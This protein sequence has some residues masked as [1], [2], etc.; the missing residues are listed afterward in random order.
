MQKNNRVLVVFPGKQAS[1]TGWGGVFN[2]TI[3]HIK[4]LIAAE[5]EVIVWTASMPIAEAAEK[6]GAQVDYDPIWHRGLDPL[7]AF[8]CWRKARALKRKGLLGAIHEGGRTGLWGRLLFSGIPQ[9][10]VMHRERIASYRTFKD[11]L[12]LSEGYKKELQ[13]SKSGRRKRIAVAPNA[14]KFDPVDMENPAASIKKNPAPKIG[15][16]GRMEPVKGIDLLIEAAD[17]LKQSGLSFSMELAGGDGGAYRETVH[18][19]GLSEIISFPGWHDRPEE[20]Y[21]HWDIFCLPSRNEPFGLSLIEAMAT[22]IPAV[23]S[24]CNGPADIIEDGVSGFLTPIE[25]ADALAEKLTLLIQDNELR[26]QMGIA[27]RERIKNNYSPRAVGEKIMLALEE[28]NQA[29]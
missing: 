23:A 24:Q 29:R 20:I 2:A 27:A 18:A 6:A 12:V 3:G 15:F 21:A 25:N 8:R 14:L 4:A 13:A 28:L 16:M 9:A 10:G 11:L 17:K 7:F 5:A 26:Q 22:G 19:K 1:G